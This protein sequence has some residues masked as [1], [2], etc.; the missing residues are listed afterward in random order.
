[1]PVNVNG[2][3]S[4][5]E[6][7]RVS[8]FD[9]GFLY[10]D[11][12]YETM[13]TFGKRPFLA[14]EHFGRLRHSA[15]A[16]GMAVPWNDDELAGEIARTVEP[17]EAEEYYIRLIVTR[18]VG[19]IGYGE[20]PLQKPTL[21]IIARPFKDFPKG[22]YEQGI[23]LITSSLRRNPITA[24]NPANKTSNLLNSRL[25]YMEAAS[26]GGQEGVLLNI[27]GNLT[28]CS[29]SNV[30]FVRGRLVMTPA[31]SEGL[32][33]GITRKLVLDL[34]RSEG[35][36]PYEAAISTEEAYGSDEA[37]ITSTLKDIM[38][39]ARFDERSF[40]PPVPG[41]VTSALMRSFRD[42]VQRFVSSAQP[43]PSLK[44]HSPSQ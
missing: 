24:L 42:H 8:V 23:A 19:E 41:P 1:M 22:W 36:E 29:A 12:V 10:G 16:I 11:S 20:N 27:E 3:I 13:R 14:P 4:V 31:L 40:G 44:I 38:P 25:A 30:F 37:F 2:I 17:L 43:I 9:H 32:L 5:D 39:V 34:A 35:F 7:G 18:G 15:Q 26:K 21:V 28:E 6:E 33:P